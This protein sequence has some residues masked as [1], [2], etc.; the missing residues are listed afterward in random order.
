MKGQST[1][2][3]FHTM[4]KLRWGIIGTGAIAHKFARGVLRSETGELA[5]A[6]SRTE[7]KARE[8]AQLYQIPHAHGSYDALLADPDV[9]IVYIATPHPQHR[10][11]ALRAAQAKKHILCEKPVGVHHD[12]AVE[13]LQA[14]W[15]NNVFFMEAYMYRC[16][17]QISRMLELLRAGA[18]DDVRTIT[19]RFSFR[20]AYDLEGRLFNRTLGGGG[21][22]DVGGYC[23]SL[24]RL[25]AGAAQGVAVEPERIFAVGQIGPE[26]GVDEYAAALLLFPGDIVA[27]LSCGLRLQQDNEVRIEGAGGSLIL[28]TPWV[29]NVDGGETQILVRKNGQAPEVITVSSAPL[30]ALEA[31]LVAHH[32]A[33]GHREAA[34]PAM[35]WADT[36]GNMRVQ[37]QWRRTLDATGPSFAEPPPGKKTRFSRLFQSVLGKNSDGH[38]QA[39]GPVDENR[40]KFLASIGHTEQEF[41]DWKKTQPLPFSTWEQR[42]SRLFQSAVEKYRQGHEKAN[43][44]VDREGRNFLASIGHTEGEFFDFVEDFAKVGEPSLETVLKIASVRRDYFLKE[45]NGAPSPHRISMDDL[46]AKDAEIEGIRWLPRVILKAEAKLRGEMP[47]DLM[48]GCS[49]DRKFCRINHVDPVDFLRKVWEAHGNRAEI[50]AWVKA[51]STGN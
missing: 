11:W 2:K 16:H 39:D 26:S 5:A 22:L 4:S 49:G 48:Y 20:A 47:P 44:L 6:A 10:E 46:P 35:T 36:L 27:T 9:D 25:V 15:E 18:I 23:T 30:Y 42:F 13:M 45:Q 28:P 3:V 1:K 33:Q 40:R 43:G 37:D 38:Q 21:I 32:I 19:A 7:S 8:F 31:D 24:A 29:A 17:P 12:E 50:V 14:A 41:F 51:K 34:W